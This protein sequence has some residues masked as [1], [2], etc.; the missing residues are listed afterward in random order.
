M[1]DKNGKIDNEINCGSNPVQISFLDS[2]PNGTQL[3]I[4]LRECPLENRDIKFECLG[5][6]KGD[7][8]QNYIALVDL[9]NKSDL[10]IPQYRCAMVKQN[11]ITHEIELII[12]SDSSCNFERNS[13]FKKDIF[14]LLPA[15]PRPST[16]SMCTFDN[17]FL[18]NWEQLAVKSDELIFKDY[19]SFNILKMKC[20]SNFGQDK[21]AVLS[22]SQCGTEIRQCIMIKARGANILEFQVGE[23]PKGSYGNDVCA[24]AKFNETQWLTMARTDE[25]ILEAECPTQGAYIGVIPDAKGICSRLI[26]HCKSKDILSYEVFACEDPEVVYEERQYQCLGKWEEQLMT[27]S[28]V[29]RLDIP[30]YECFV[31][32]KAG[33]DDRRLFIEEAGENCDR[34]SDPAKYGMEMEKIGST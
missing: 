1:E 9:R 29:R 6:W 13:P 34:R 16:P 15:P 14:S 10:H 31:G 19:I 2:C 4:R 26:T 8:S 30:S 3:L 12:T 23:L 27:F 7:E 11:F 5:Q 17:N 24:K 18:G 28:Y 33:N 32:F 20:L 25:S 21:Y 22:R